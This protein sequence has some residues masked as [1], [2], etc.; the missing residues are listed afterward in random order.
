MAPSSS[1]SKRVTDTSREPMRAIRMRSV[2]DLS[3][4][5]VGSIISDAETIAK[6]QDSRNVVK[7]GD[8]YLRLTAHE[9]TQNYYLYTAMSQQAGG[10]YIVLVPSS[11]SLYYADKGTASWEVPTN[12]VPSST[13][14]SSSSTD[15][16]Y[17]SAKCVYDYVNTLVGNA[18]TLLGTG[19]IS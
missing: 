6:L 3:S 4:Y 13:G 7:V 11:G 16:Q 2:I 12:K 5:S 19:V 15:T 17:P 1:D 8:A 14:L 10:D 9:T 18:D